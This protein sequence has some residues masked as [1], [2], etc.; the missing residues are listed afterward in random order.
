[1][2]FLSSI[3]DVHVNLFFV[4]NQT[5]EFFVCRMYFFEYDENYFKSRVNMHI[6]SL[7]SL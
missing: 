7:G 1:M 5:M 2:I 4:E 6:S 3:L